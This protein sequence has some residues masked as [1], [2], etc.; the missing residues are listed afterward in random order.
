MALRRQASATTPGGP[1][2]VRILVRPDD[3]ATLA[4]RLSG[5]TD[6]LNDSGETMAP[7]Y[8]VL[9]DLSFIMECLLEQCYSDGKSE[10]WG[11]AGRLE[12]DPAYAIEDRD[13]VAAEL[14]EAFSKMGGTEK[15]GGYRILTRISRRLWKSA[16]SIYCVQTDN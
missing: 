10:L 8:K 1:R 2:R 7:V 5:R 15:R 4:H 16:A 11:L 9:D 3:C 13:I 6:D 12:N 14:H